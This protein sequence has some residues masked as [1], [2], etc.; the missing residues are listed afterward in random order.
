MQVDSTDFMQSDLQCGGKMPLHILT[1]HEDFSPE[2]CEYLNQMATMLI[3][4]GHADVNALFHDHTPLSWCIVRGNTELLRSLLETNRVDPNKIISEEIGVPL[5]VVLSEKLTAHIDVDTR[6]KML[7]HNYCA[8]F[9][10]SLTS[11]EL[12]ILPQTEANGKHRHSLVQ[13]AAQHTIMTSG[14]L[15]CAN[16]KL[17]SATSSVLAQNFKSKLYEKFPNPVKILMIKS[18]DGEK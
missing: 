7:W 5:T 14:P 12:P 6:L 15:N 11:N 16:S 1:M 10:I 4:Q 17:P 3:E 2:N 18:F 8:I 9:Y 13:C